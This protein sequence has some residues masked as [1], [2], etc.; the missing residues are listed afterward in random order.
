MKLPGQNNMPVQ[1]LGRERAPSIAGEMSLVSAVTDQVDQYQ[2]RKAQHQQA[3]ADAAM[4]TWDGDFKKKYDGVDAIE[5]DSLPRHLQKDYAGKTSVPAFEVRARLYEEESSQR[6]NEIAETIDGKFIREQWLLSK[7]EALAGHIAARHEASTKEQVAYYEK[8]SIAAAQEALDDQ[9]YSVAMHLINSSTLD[10]VEKKERITEIERRRELDLVNDTVREGSIEELRE[11][12]QLY[13]SDYDG[14]LDSSQALTA[15]RALEGRLSHLVEVERKL[16]IGRKA[17]DYVNKAL[18][19]P[20]LP[21]GVQN[22]L[23]DGIKDDAVKQEARK[24]IKA[25][26]EELKR[27]AE[28][29]QAAAESDFLEQF[30]KQPWALD[31]AAA[32]TLAAEKEA[33]QY[34]EQWASGKSAT[35]DWKHYRSLRQKVINGES[36]NLDLH[37]TR[38]AD[39]EFKELVNLQQAGPGSTLAKAAM[40]VDQDIDSRLREMGFYPENMNNNTASGKRAAAMYRV[41]E[42]ELSIAE[43]QKGSDLTA[44]ERRELFDQIQIMEATREPSSILGFEFGGGQVTIDDIPDSEMPD[45]IEAVRAAG[46][47]PT[48]ANILEIYAGQ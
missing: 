21:A 8:E 34:R 33:R 38:L 29:E 36:V 31:P 17:E 40:T 13:A 43:E 16:E 19:D 5:V 45:I 44:R 32:P 41:F 18:A 26:R 1:S 46:L 7:Q 42:T 15:K 4:A 30:R 27:V 37:L 6:L 28:E 25:R 12:H 22:E 9:N 3:L 39:T 11:L 24:R 23:I 48:T 10:G 14:P 35:T 20:T 47:E 2:Q